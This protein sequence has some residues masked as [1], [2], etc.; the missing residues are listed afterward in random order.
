MIERDARIFAKTVSMR[1]PCL[2]L[3]ILD[4]APMVFM[5]NLLKTV[6]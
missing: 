6:G 2:F 1:D 3:V 5:E 4:Q